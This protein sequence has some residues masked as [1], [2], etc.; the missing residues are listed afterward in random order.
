M[1]NNP[2]RFSIADCYNNIT[3]ELQKKAEKEKG[4]KKEGKKREKK[5]KKKENWPFC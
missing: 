4:G 5:K 3:A 2:F 1:K